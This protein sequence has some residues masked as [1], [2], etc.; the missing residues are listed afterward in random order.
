MGFANDTVDMMG[1]GSI[2]L[3]ALTAISKG[4][5]MNPAAAKTLA[6]AAKAAADK[7][8]KKV[9]VIDASRPPFHG[10]AYSGVCNRQ[11]CTYDHHAGRCQAFKE[12][13]P[14]GPPRK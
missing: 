10:I 3:L 11:G 2:A 6:N 4:L 7:A 14:E 5:K 12:A 8:A 13:N 9:K 1:Y